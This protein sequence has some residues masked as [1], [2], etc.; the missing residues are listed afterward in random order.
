MSGEGIVFERNKPIRFHH[1]DPAGIVFYPQ[2]FVL[3]N[4]LVEDWFNEAL[5]VD[6]GRFHL[7]SR[8]GIPMG[9]I[10]CRFLAPSKVGDQLQLA[11]RVNRIGSS[12]IELEV[13]ARC[14]G[15]VRVEANLT[16]IV[17][18]LDSR[19]SVPLEGEFRER[20]ARF[21]VSK[22]APRE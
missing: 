13:I 10:E 14:E 7:E 18:S 6:F 4:E 21:L 5:D 19:R 16:I 17:A 1:C 11:L 8:L 12:S 15:L 20:V 22:S 9:R 2:Y 3:F